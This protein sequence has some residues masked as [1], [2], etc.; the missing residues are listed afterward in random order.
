M[1]GRV[2]QRV[3]VMRHDRLD[4]QL[5][6]SDWNLPLSI[7]DLSLVLMQGVFWDGTGKSAVDDGQ[8]GGKSVL[9]SNFD[10]KN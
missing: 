7:S 3:W 6:M 10:T 9:R 4:L 1:D 5:A 8:M 2:V